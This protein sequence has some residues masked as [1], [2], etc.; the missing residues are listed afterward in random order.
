M[1]SAIGES[2][3][4]RPFELA[5]VPNPTLRTGFALYVLTSGPTCL[6]IDPGLATMGAAVLTPTGQ[7]VAAGA[8]KNPPGPIT[9]PGYAPKM[10]DRAR[11]VT[12]AWA[13]LNGWWH[14]R[15]RIIVAE[16][17]GSDGMQSGDAIASI[18]AGETLVSLLAFELGV[19]IAWVTPREWRRYF[20]PAPAPRM[21]RPKQ[22]RK[23][24]IARHLRECP[25]CRAAVAASRASGKVGVAIACPNYPKAK[26]PR[27]VPNPMPSD[28]ELYTAIGEPVAAAIASLIGG[29]ARGPDVHAIDSAGIGRWGLARSAEVQR[30]LGIIEGDQL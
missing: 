28:A 3:A 9:A 24:E 21:S 16:A 4:A 26:A 12:V 17:A 27:V 13:W 20:V 7:I 18:H 29:A 11:R 22:P 10:A 8:L 23:R 19:S 14:W 15:P 6:A 5:P 30:S 2:G 1:R 25:N